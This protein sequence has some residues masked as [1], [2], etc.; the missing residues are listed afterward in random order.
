VVIW[1]DQQLTLYQLRETCYQKSSRSQFFHDLYW[2]ILAKY[3]IPQEQ[4]QAIKDFLKAIR[5]SSN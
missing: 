1:Q 2:Q 3:L 5:S 4:P